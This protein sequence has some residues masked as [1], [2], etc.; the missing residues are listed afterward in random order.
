MTD[1]F[2]KYRATFDHLCTNGKLFTGIK[3]PKGFRQ[4]RRKDCFRNSQILAIDGRATYV[5]GLC[6]HR[7]GG[8]AFAHGW[9]TL[10]GEHAIDVTLS[11]A[12]SYA[13]FGIT[14]ADAHELAKAILKTG[15]YGTRL[16]LD[17]VMDVP[18]QLLVETA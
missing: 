15:Y 6:I 8:V 9:L 12:E 3:R 14:F 11:D 13:Y 16:G 1:A 5:E 18:P 10:D 7:S 17:A 2:A 4:M